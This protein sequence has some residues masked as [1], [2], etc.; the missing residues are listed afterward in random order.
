VAQALK[1]RRGSARRNAGRGA[2]ASTIAWRGAGGTARTV[3]HRSA[4]LGAG[5][6]GV[7]SEGVLGAWQQGQAQAPHPPDRRSLQDMGAVPEGVASQRATMP[8]PRTWANDTARMMRQR[9]TIAGDYIVRMGSPVPGAGGWGTIP[10][11][12]RGLAYPGRGGWGG[13]STPGWGQACR[14]RRLLRTTLMLEK[15]M[16]AL[17]MMGERSQPVRG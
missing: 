15:A 5:V 11:F 2:D 7:G 6:A 4:V 16:A 9:N 10:G 13:G 3:S 8:G 1:A 14:R 17:A 12:A